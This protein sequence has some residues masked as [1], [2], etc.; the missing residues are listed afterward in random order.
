[1][2]ACMRVTALF[3]AAAGA[4][5]C[6]LRVV[7]AVSKRAVVL[8]GTMH[9]NP[10]S[11][12]LAGSTVRCVAKQEAL[13]AV[14][15]EL[16]ESRWD[17]SA[18]AKWSRKPSF[19]RFMSEDE[20]QVAFE[21]AIDC[22][23]QDVVLADQDI[24]VTGERLLAALLQTCRDCVTPSGWRRVSADVGAAMDQIPSFLRSTSTPRLISG[25][26]IAF[27]RY[28]YQSPAAL[29]FLAISSGA[30]VV[31]AAIDEVTGALPAVEDAL[32]T[33]AV[34]MTVGRA[35][36][37][38]LIDE[39][40]RVLARNIR[41]SCLASHAEGQGAVGDDKCQGSDGVVVAIIGMAHLQGVRLALLTDDTV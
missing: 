14:A 25:V 1:M 4:N 23:L 36:Y 7:D 28:L 38:S 30:L 21:A 37:V 35:V 27:C 18:A 15:I 20:F 12:E 26:P 13:H 34:A 32:V 33:A 41:T 2:R 40:N 5:G 8:V 39:R 9:Y 29:P 17:T 19:K 10:A 16:C 6:T 24:R 11:V 3:L 31:A 22:G